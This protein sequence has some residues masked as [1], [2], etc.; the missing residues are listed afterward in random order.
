MDE[1]AKKIRR[2]NGKTDITPRF[3]KDGEFRAYDEFA[4]TGVGRSAFIWWS[5]DITPPA[6]PRTYPCTQTST[7]TEIFE[8]TNA[9][10]N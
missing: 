10:S 9:D 1:K 6:A 3:G 4:L 5:G 2:V 8:G 7:V